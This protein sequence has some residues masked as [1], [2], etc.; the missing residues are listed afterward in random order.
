MEIGDVVLSPS[1]TIDSVP[2]TDPVIVGV[3]LKLIFKEDPEVA[4]R[5]V[6][7]EGSVKVKQGLPDKE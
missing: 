6:P 4:K 3:N 5:K 1:C 7:E 2:E